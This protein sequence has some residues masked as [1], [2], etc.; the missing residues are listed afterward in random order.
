MGAPPPPSPGEVRRQEFA[1][2]LKTRRA[3][4]RPADIGL[5]DDGRRR[6]TPGL[7][8]EEV[9]QHAGVGIS[10]YTWLE[11]GRDVSPSPQ[12]LDALARA[13]R[14]SPAEHSHLFHLAGIERPVGTAPYPRT[15][16]P[17]LVEI[18]EA[19]LPHAAY[20]LGPRLDVLAYNTSA[21]LVMPGLIAA[22]PER[23][24]LLWWLFGTDWS[25]VDTW[26]ATARA[27][28]ATFRAEYA[29]RPAD[30][31]FVDLVAALSAASP[32]FG[33]WWAEHDVR[34]YEPV[35]KT[36]RHPRLGELRTHQLQ[37][38]PAG[39][40]ELRLRVLVPAD[41]ATRAALALPP[42]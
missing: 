20:L 33:A 23:R 10:W 36:I 14:L 21:A 18:I 12:V 1:D 35:R 28:L 17:E 27:N 37:S 8:R 3:A 4:V 40:P 15:A 9:A 19:L 24:N 22:P 11:Q 6:R 41:D 5:A 31:S 25:T 13:L 2:F 32:V 26:E 30:P 34:A 7:R 29:R 42:G 16:P 38:V 39:Y